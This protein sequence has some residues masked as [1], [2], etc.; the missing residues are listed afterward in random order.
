[1]NVA[2]ASTSNAVQCKHA[3]S[4]IHFL[5]VYALCDTVL[6]MKKPSMPYAVHTFHK[7]THTQS[8]PFSRQY[9]QITQK[10]LQLNHSRAF[11]EYAYENET[12]S[13]LRCN[14]LH[15]LRSV[16]CEFIRYHACISLDVQ[17]IIEQFNIGH[18]TIYTRNAISLF[19]TNFVR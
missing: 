14:T 13:S 11:S 4:H 1:M 17:N 3:H 15:T 12:L 6:S 9:I 16:D 7:R 5:H 10:H 2:I 18:G 8:F 19:E